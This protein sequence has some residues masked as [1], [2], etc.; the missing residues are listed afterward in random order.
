MERHNPHNP[1]RPENGATADRRDLAGRAKQAEEAGDLMRA[2][3]LYCE[4]T[5]IAYEAVKVLAAANQDYWCRQ[6]ATETRTLSWE[7]NRVADKVPA[8][9]MGVMREARNRGCEASN[10]AIDAEELADD[11]DAYM[12]DTWAP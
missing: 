7:A 5:A 1:T 12:A 9:S 4:A 2:L 8:T 3:S 11:T 6:M 10:W